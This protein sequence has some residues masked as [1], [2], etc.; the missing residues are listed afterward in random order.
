MSKKTE[1]YTKQPDNP[2]TGKTEAARTPAKSDPQQYPAVNKSYRG[3]YAGMDPCNKEGNTFLSGAE[4]IIGTELF[5]RQTDPG[6]GLFTRDNRH[7]AILE[8]SRSNELKE[9]IGQD[10]TVHC[11]LAYTLYEAEKKNF[12]AKLACFCYA[13]SIAENQKDAL[14]TFIRNMTDR[15]ASA[16]NPSLA[17]TQEQLNRVLDS[18]GAWYFAKGEPWPELPRGSVYYRR[19]RTYKDRLIEIALKGNKGCLI[20]SW[21]AMFVVIAAIIYA[22]WRFFF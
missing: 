11:V 8:K 7:I 14:E 18:K 19:K 3:F 6:L 16:A 15:I 13:P 10:W 17:L 2:T 12:S 9:M 22:I 21:A 4:G 20:A 5:V 1:R